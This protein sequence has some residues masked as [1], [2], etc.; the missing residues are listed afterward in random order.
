MAAN[1][2]AEIG[3]IKRFPT[4]SRL[5]KYAG[6]A[7]VTYASGKSDWQFANERG[8]RKL[9]RI[10]F[11]L[12]VRLIMASGQGTKITNHYFY[13][14]Y[15]KK[16]TEGKTKK[17]ALKCLERRLVNIIWGMMKNNTEYINPPLLD[18]PKEETAESKP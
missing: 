11:R 12:A 13:D 2:I 10:F 17:Q 6:V 9:N 4:A 14:Y 18:K 3:D 15:R 8:N 1:L 16:Q 7:P 5:A